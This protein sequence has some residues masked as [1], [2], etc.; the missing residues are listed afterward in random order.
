MN[1]TE[2]ATKALSYAKDEAI[3]AGLGS[4][5]TEH[6]LLGLLKATDSAASRVLENNGVTY[7]AVKTMISEQIAPEKALLVKDKGLYTPKAMQILRASEDEARHF[8]DTKIGCE[9]ILLAILTE[10]DNLALRILNSLNVN[11][12]KMFVDTLAAMGNEIDEIKEEIR[13]Y[14]AYNSDADMKPSLI[15]KY[16]RD[17][18]KLAEEGR[19]DPVIG[20]TEEINRII[21]TISRRTKNNPCLV[22]EPGV[23]KTAIVEGLAQRI[24]SGD[25][26]K[27]IRSKRLLTLDL[28]AMVAGSKYRGEFEERIKKVIAE[29]IEAGN[30]ILFLDEIHTLIGAGGSE[31]SI[32]ASNILKPSLARGEIQLI[33]ATTHDEYRKYVTKDA[34]LER[35]FQ[36]ID[37]PEPDEAT[38]IEIIK[39]IKHK[40]EEHH[41]VTITDDAVEACVTLS[42]RY[43]SDRY[44][45]DKAIDLMDEAAS[46]IRLFDKDKSAKELEELD[47]KL[48]SY[49][50]E[51]L[52]ALKAGDV[53]RVKE[54]KDLQ[55]KLEKS[56]ASKVKKA[57]SS[58]RGS[59]YVVTKDTIALVVGEWTKI[60]VSRINETESAKLLKLEKELKKRVVGQ[61]TAVSAVARAVKRGRVGLKE[62]NRPIGSFL[63][64][65]PTGVGKTELSKALAEAL[66]GSEDAL[67]RIDMS[68]Y[69]EKHTVSKMIGSP[70]GYVGFDE[71]GQLSEKVRR[72][73]Y[74][75]V[76]FDEIE[77]AHPDVFNILL[78]VLDDG[79]I[80][81][82]TGRKVSF[83]NCVIIMTSNAGANRIV[84]PKKLG[85]AAVEDEKMDYDKMKSGVM[86]EIKLIFKPE[87]INR[88]D[89]IVVF[90]M[91]NEADM[92]KIATI[93]TGSLVKRAKE[94]MGIDLTITD[95]AKKLLVKKGSDKKFGARPLKRAIQTELEDIL[96][97]EIL[98]GNIKE[99]ARVK[100]KVSGEKIVI[101]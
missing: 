73:P 22:G 12:Q 51:M 59:R 84:D 21:R 50:E 8:K 93:L 18:T 31:G 56:R 76:L 6:L 43:I 55:K 100:T 30:I 97:E 77:K 9:H 79:H 10:G 67:I 63:F 2:I 98:K 75:V 33:G 89:E 86:D 40:Y 57:E 38:A 52:E 74:S 81:D 90:R 46:G 27:T 85:F 69:M 71:G 15:A 34:A 25:V 28:S 36:P 92:M 45:P 87:F 48:L 16:S 83:K 101:V 20:R 58:T 91:L 64:L 54:L 24:V 14:E 53:T 88:I 49:E 26:P 7:D 13:A 60:P 39:G 68:E 65:G 41:G 17:L 80:T 5:G 72:N 96:S 37:V 44:L 70:P 99:G 94:Y 95:A 4:I 42:A 47:L 66:F 61:E 32:D 23:G 82:S 35:R 29:V 1:F 3:K 11:P 78:Q 62:K 19:L